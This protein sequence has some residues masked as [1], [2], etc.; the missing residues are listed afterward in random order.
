MGV[1]TLTSLI[2]KEGPWLWLSVLGN[3]PGNIYYARKYLYSARKSCT[4]RRKVVIPSYIYY[5]CPQTF[6]LVRKHF[7][8]RRNIKSSCG[9]LF[10]VRGNLFIARG[11]L[12]AARKYIHCAR[13]HCARKL[14][15]CAEIYSLCAE[16]YVLRGSIFK[17][18]QIFLFV[19]GN[20]YVPCADFGLPAILG[21][22]SC[23][24]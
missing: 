20:Y 11:N 18:P 14:M 16:T 22:P 15:C 2:T 8:L 3:I 7:S 13:I 17:S 12:C 5:L 24:D 21:M 9:N 4:V 10:T 6:I 23:R 19:R 1:R